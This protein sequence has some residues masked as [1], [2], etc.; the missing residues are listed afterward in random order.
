[1][2]AEVVGARRYEDAL[3]EIAALQHA[4]HPHPRASAWALY[5]QVESHFWR[6]EIGDAVKGIDAMER[7]GLDIT[8][9]PNP[10]FYAWVLT[11]AR[12]RDR[13]NAY[14]ERCNDGKRSPE[15]TDYGLI[16]A[17]RQRVLDGEPAAAWPV[18]QPR[19]DAL[20]RLRAPSRQ[21][22]EALALMTRHAVGLP[23]VDP[24]RLQAAR[25]VVDRVA[26]LD[27]AGP[28]LRLGADLLRGAR[29]GESVV[30]G[31][32]PPRALPDWAREDRLAVRL[33]GSR[34]ALR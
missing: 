15:Q 34:P 33:S 8:A 24:R 26:A 6:D 31:D 18:L 27:G 12:R 22:A 16:A 5:L 1:V 19:V 25:Q 10:C 17:A 4:P 11:E 21:E 20:S 23:G 2:V 32:C 7:A 28:A 3:A 14:L 9:S 13:A 30:D 29:C